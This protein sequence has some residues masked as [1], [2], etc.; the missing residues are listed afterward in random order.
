MQK[1]EKRARVSTEH[2]TPTKEGPKQ[3]SV[4]GSL[5]YS[6]TSESKIES[7]CKHWHFRSQISAENKLV[8][9]QNGAHVFY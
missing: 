9:K 1:L 8:E 3:N 6:V 2:L 5:E 7:V 4:H